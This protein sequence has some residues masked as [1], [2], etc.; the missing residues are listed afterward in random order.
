MTEPLVHQDTM[1]SVTIEQI[2]RL[3]R[4]LLDMRSEAKGS[5]DIL[6]MIA[7]INYQEI[8][9][10]R[11]EL[12]LSLGVAPS[13]A[14]DLVMSLQ[15][16]ELGFGTAPSS[17][18]SSA[19]G[20]IRNSMQSILHYLVTGRVAKKGRPPNWL[21]D[22]TDFQFGGIAG[23]SVRMMLNLPKSRV[24]FNEQMQDP[25]HRGMELLL[26]TINWVSSGSEVDVLVRRV[27]DPQ[28]VKLLLTQ[29]RGVVPARNG[30]VEQVEFYGK[31]AT[32]KGDH[33]LMPSSAARIKEALQEITGG[34]RR[35]VEHGFLR[36]VDKDRGVFELRGRPGNKPD[37]SCE[38]SS[39]L[40]D[41]ALSYFVS[42]TSAS[43]EGIQRFD[44]YGKPTRLIVDNIYEYGTR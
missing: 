11:G 19:L 5:P 13:H 21:S 16:R 7:L 2:S 37:I 26:S 17:V 33:I 24:H 41:R 40:L 31:L 20:N 30:I 44:N 9:R 25:V 36:A 1:P 18:I 6:D 8:V 14:S 27:K 23:G 29:V 39:E 22:A 34:E 43:V 38:I 32:L 10:L 3:E 15:G 42:D 28:L 12:D 4:A 35:V